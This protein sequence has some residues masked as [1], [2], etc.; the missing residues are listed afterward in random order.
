MFLSAARREQIVVQ[1]VTRSVSEGFAETL[2]KRKRM[3]SL[4]DVSGCDGP[5]N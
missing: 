5:L 4:T 1:I 3:H 2:D